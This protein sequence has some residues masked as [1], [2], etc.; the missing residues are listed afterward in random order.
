[1]EKEYRQE[2]R[3]CGSGGQGIIMA[4]IVLAEAAGVYDGKHVCQTQS[5][6]PEARGGTCKA[7]VVISS[8][9]IDYPKA[10]RPSLLLAMN[11]ASCDTYFPDLKPAGLLIVDNTLVRKVPIGRV[12]AIPFTQIA[13]QN[14][15]REMASNMVALGA[16]GYLCKAVSMEGLESAL[17]DRVPEGTKDLNLKALR[18]G[19]EAAK[20]L[21]LR[22]LPKFVGDDDEVM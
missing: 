4:A 7:D 18:A 2:I 11:Q 19:V 6:G 15:G 21:D 8:K 1:M 9:E 16:F 5:Y 3:L 12:A 22:A 17:M 20:E 13:R 14:I 10:S